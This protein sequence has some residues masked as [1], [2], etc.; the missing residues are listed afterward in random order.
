MSISIAEGREA[1]L[2]T[3]RDR[4]S[5]GQLLALDTSGRVVARRDEPLYAG[6]AWVISAEPKAFR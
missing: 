4:C 1:T 6:D 2:R 3:F 5:G